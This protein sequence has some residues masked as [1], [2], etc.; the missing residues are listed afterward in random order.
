MSSTQSTGLEEE[1]HMIKVDRELLDP[2]PYRDFTINP[3]S[4]HQVGELIKSYRKNGDFGVI[5]VRKVG[6][7]YEIA[8]GHHRLSAMVEIGFHK[9]DCKLGEFSDDEMVSLMVSENAS[10]HGGKPSSQADSVAAAIKRLGF[11][12]MAS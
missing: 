8:C 5:P 9:I 6:D 12:M 11:W 2:N 3:I 1:M 7:R 4:Q 10:Q